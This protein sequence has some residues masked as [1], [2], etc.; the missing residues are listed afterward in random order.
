[1]SELHV[2]PLDDVADELLAEEWRNVHNLIVPT[3]PLTSEEV[4]ERRS[5][6]RLFV[7]RAMG[8]V[9]GCSTVRPPAAAEGVAT[10]IA[11]ILPEHRRRG[12]GTALYAHGLALAREL[13]AEAVETVVL[14]SNTE[15]LDFARARG[16][17]EVETYLLPGDT[18]PF[19]DLRLT[20][21]PEGR[22]V[23]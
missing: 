21:V 23:A 19:V 16:F 14:G 5:R 18:V 20:E 10:V 3:A 15:G 1:M 11:R 8:E 12:F 22:P 9:V 2:H 6:N 13:G 7:A 4:R 17:V